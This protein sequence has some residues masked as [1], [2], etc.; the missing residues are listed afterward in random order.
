[1]QCMRLTY[2]YSFIS[3]WQWLLVPAWCW[4]CS[5]RGTRY[6]LRRRQLTSCAWLYHVSNQST[7]SITN[8][9]LANFMIDMLTSS[10][11]RS[12]RSVKSMIWERCKWA[13]WCLS[14]LISEGE[15]AMMKSAAQ[16]LYHRLVHK[17]NPRLFYHQQQEQTI[18]HQSSGKT[19]PTLTK[20]ALASTR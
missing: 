16:F 13:S 19:C 2:L 6:L 12:I 11:K 9:D 20:A 18:R 10:C 4:I 14:H 7:H 3:F 8:I 15:P 1:M 5:L 17:L